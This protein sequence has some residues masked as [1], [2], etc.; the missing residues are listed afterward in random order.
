[1]HDT[2]HLSQGSFVNGRHILDGVLVANEVIDKRSSFG[3]LAIV[4]KIDF[5]KTCYCADWG[6]LDHVLG[7]KGFSLK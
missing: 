6:F 5:E 1:M 4:F 3:N 7:R 2:I